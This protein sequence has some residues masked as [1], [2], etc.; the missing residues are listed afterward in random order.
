M[1]A[2]NEFALVRAG[3]YEDSLDDVEE[4][5]LPC[6]PAGHGAIAMGSVQSC[7]EFCRTFVGS[8]IVIDWI[9]N[10]Y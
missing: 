5:E 1:R 7:K 2:P 9:E 10:G 6:E 8:A 4:T 3:R